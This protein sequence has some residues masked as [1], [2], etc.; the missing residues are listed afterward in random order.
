MGKWQYGVVI[1]AGS[2]GSRVHVYKWLK[3]SKALSRGTP[4]SLSSLPVLETKKKWTH[5][6]HPGI[7]TFAETPSLVGPEHLHDL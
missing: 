1:D 4:A 6:I 5:K 3:A 2:S 7:S